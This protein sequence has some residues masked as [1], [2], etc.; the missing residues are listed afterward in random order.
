MNMTFKKDVNLKSLMLKH[1]ILLQAFGLI[2]GREGVLQTEKELFLMMA[3]LDNL[4]EEDL[5]AECNED[6]RD[7]N[8]ILEVE[9]EPKFLDLLEQNEY[10]SFYNELRELFLTRC[11][12]IWDNQHSFYGVLDALLEMIASMDDEDK[13]EALVATGKIAEQA[14]ERRTAKMEAKTEEVNSKLTALVD[15]YIR[16]SKEQAEQIKEEKNEDTAE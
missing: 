15:Q 11:K 4:V 9:L 3:M 6:E 1:N 2:E 14:F 8:T 16:Q 5:I 13:K 10:K 12:E 7:L